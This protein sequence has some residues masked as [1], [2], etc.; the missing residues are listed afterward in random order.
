MSK[1]ILIVEDDPSLAE[2]VRYNLTKE[3][4]NAI[5]VGDGETAVVAV[6]E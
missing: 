6:E 5:V 4:F 2:L 1:S 3:G